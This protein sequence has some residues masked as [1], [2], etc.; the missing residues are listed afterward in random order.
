MTGRRGDR[1]PHR[2][3]ASEIAGSSPADQIHRPPG[4]SRGRGVAVL[5]SLMSSRPWVR[6]P[7]A[8]SELDPTE[9]DR[10]GSSTGGSGSDGTGLS[11]AR[12]LTCSW[13]DKPPGPTGEGVAASQRRWQDCREVQQLAP[14]PSDGDVSALGCGEPI[15]PSIFLASPCDTAARV[16]VDHAHPIVAGGRLR[17]PRGR[18]R[19]ICA[20]TGRRGSWGNHGVPH[21]AWRPWCNGQHPGS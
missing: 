6:I 14:G 15:P 9:L 12:A 13:A 10:N 5:A 21:A 19:V 17:R 18:H 20:Q 7:P 11:R 16:S 1:P 2:L 8:P 4:A 3:R